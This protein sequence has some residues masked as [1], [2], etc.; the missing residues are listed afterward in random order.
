MRA[1]GAA[2]GV[3]GGF[4]IAER[5]LRRGEKAR[6][7][8]PGRADR[9]STTAIGAAFG[10]AVLTLIVAP[11][12]D[13]PKVGRFGGQRGPWAG[14]VLMLAGLGLRIWALRVLGSSYTRTLQTSPEQRI[15]A[16]GPYRVVRHP[17]YLGDLL[18]WIGAGLATANWLIAAIVAFPMAAVY[19]YR[20]AVEEAMLSDAFPGDYEKYASR[21]WRLIPRVY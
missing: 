5:L 18:L 7:L 17:G 12:L 20:V 10:A 21:T 6:S 14:V 8:R 19:L 3:L 1:I 2:Y 13:R 16:A 9:G 15:V 11:V 4:F